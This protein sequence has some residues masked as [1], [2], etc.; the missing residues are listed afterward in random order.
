MSGPAFENA[1]TK[2]RE[3]SDEVLTSIERYADLVGR[4]TNEQRQVHVAAIFNRLAMLNVT[5]AD[6][7]RLSSF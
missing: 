1:L 4:S 7:M 6:L 3:A 5:L 2:A